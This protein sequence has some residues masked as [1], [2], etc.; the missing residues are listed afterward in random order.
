M[1]AD[2]HLQS[3]WPYFEAWCDDAGD[4]RTFLIVDFSLSLDMGNSK[5]KLLV[6][7]SESYSLKLER[8]PRNGKATLPCQPTDRRSRRRDVSM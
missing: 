8:V 5:Y 6:F 7:S 1:T 2:K 3:N 4:Q